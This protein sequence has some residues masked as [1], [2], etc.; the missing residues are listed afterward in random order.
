MPG[1]LFFL[2]LSSII[3]GATI[4]IVRYK[5]L[6]TAMCMIVMLL[7]LSFV[8]ELGSYMAVIHGKYT[9]R[10]IIFHIYGILQ[11]FLFTAYFIYAIKPFRHRMMIAFSALFWPAIGMLNIMFLQPF[12]ELN[13]NMMMAES[14]SFTTLSLYYMYY[15]LKDERIENIFSFPHFWMTFIILISWSSSIFFWAFIQILY[16]SQWQHI[17]VVFYAQAALNILVY[18]SMAAV[19]F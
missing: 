8:D 4:G 2:L 7:I 11:A 16:L 12:N 17:V 5:N 13:S 10:Y 9:A 19:L 6:D 14:C 18:V 15:L 1:W 3:L